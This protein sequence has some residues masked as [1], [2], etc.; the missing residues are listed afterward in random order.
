MKFVVCGSGSWGTAVAVH[1][2]RIGHELILVPRSEE[3]AK[4]MQE[5]RENIYY[6]PHIPFPDNLYVDT[7]YD[8]HLG[9]CDA[10]F[11]ACPMKGLVDLC[12]MLKLGY[13]KNLWTVSLIKGLDHATLCTPSNIISQFFPENP[14]ACLAGP[15]YAVEFAL[16]KPAAMV[17]ASFNPYVKPLQEAI[18]AAHTRVYRSGDLVGVETA[19]CLKNIYALGAGIL[20]GL[21]LGDNAKSAYL[22]RALK[23][24]AYLGCALGGHKETFY[25]LSG[26]GD[27]IA[28]AQGSWS[29]NRTFGELLAKGKSVESLTKELMVEGYG[30]LHGYHTL[31]NKMRLEVPILQSL[32]DILYKQHPLDTAVHDLLARPLKNEF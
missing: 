2:A 15:T 4:M 16:G 3:K 6:L 28:T 5:R 30:S 13:P 24:M 1:L 10:L 14:V 9:T 22:T 31:A 29:R 18:S 11:V 27:L 26:L 8:K 19:S 32:H 25:G 12:D 23:E 20:D 17:L 21:E 7:R